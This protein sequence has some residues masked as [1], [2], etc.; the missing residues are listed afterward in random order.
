MDR[1]AIGDDVRHSWFE[2]LLALITGTLVVAL[3]LELFRRTG[4]GS[5]G[6]PGLAFLLTYT[7]GR[8]LW[9]SLVLVNLPFYA[10]ALWRMGWVFTL[11]TIVSV[12]LLAASTWILP[13]VME[14]G[15]VDPVFGA[16]F[17][18]LMIGVGLLV[19]IRHKASL[20][21]VGILALFLQER[22]GLWAGKAQMAM[23]A[24]I[25]SATMF[26]LDPAHVG[27]SIFGAA[28]LN[29][30]LATNHR[31]GRYHGY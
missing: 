27:L 17:G 12:G 21:G 29:L 24:A 10:F 30:V 23:D 28:V 15:R 8:P 4:I 14:I 18:G 31:A 16:G 5:G 3:G 19:L 2:D 7:T 1:T 13:Q 9:S 25:L 6:A 11:K 22:V 20:G 26:V